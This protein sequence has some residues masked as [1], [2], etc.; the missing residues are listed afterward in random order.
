M[1]NCDSKILNG[2]FW[3]ETI[4]KF[5]IVCHSEGYLN[6]ITELTMTVNLITSTAS[7]LTVGSVYSMDDSCPVG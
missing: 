6:A 1:V 2:K 5:K 4:H 3:K 7:G